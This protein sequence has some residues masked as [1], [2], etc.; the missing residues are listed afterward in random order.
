MA[1]CDDGVHCWNGFVVAVLAYHAGQVRHTD[2]VEAT[3]V[4]GA[5]VALLDAPGLT[6]R[7]AALVPPPV[8]FE[9]VAR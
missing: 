4:G 6:A 7:I 5:F 9:V 2:L 8:V 1:S 3:L